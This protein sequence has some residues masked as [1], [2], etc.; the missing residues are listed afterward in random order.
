MRSVVPCVAQKPP[1]KTPMRSTAPVA[2]AVAAEGSGPVLAPGADGAVDDGVPV[3]AP[4]ADGLGRA[5]AAEPQAATSTRDAATARSRT[6]A[7]T[8][9]PLSVAGSGV[10]A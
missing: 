5:V 9:D 2:G 8:G 1:G 6:R 7:F 3:V 4:T 10:T